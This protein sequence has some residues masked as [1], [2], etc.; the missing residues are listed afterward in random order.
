MASGRFG[1][2]GARLP[3]RSAAMYGMMSALPNRGDLET[4]VVDILDRMTRP[5]PE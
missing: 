3:R 5:D 4:V 1:I 2:E